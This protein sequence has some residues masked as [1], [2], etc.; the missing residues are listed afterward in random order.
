MPRNVRSISG[1]SVV[2]D[3]RGFTRR[4]LLAGLG[5]GVGATVV[6]GACTMPAPG[7]TPPTPP[8][9]VPDPL[10]FGEG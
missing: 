8:P 9:G 7:A 5:L 3:G 1:P 4:E 6:L 10:P 2:A